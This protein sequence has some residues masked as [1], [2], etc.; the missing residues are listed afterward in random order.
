MSTKNQGKSST[1]ITDYPAHPFADAFERLSEPE[2]EEL[3]QDIAKNGQLNPVAIWKGVLLDGRNRMAACLQ[4]GKKPLVRELPESTNPIEF[5]L[6][7]NIYRRH[8]STGARAMFIIEAMKL[9]GKKLSEAKKSAKAEVSPRQLDD[10][11][12]VGKANP[13]LKTMVQAG[14]VP[15]NKAAT[16]AR[17][18]EEEQQRIVEGG[19]QAVKDAADRVKGKKPKPAKADVDLPEVF[20]DDNGDL[21]PNELWPVWRMKPQWLE[22]A[23]NIRKM[24]GYATEIRKFGKEVGSGILGEVADRIQAVAKSTLEDVIKDVP[25]VASVDGTWLSRKEAKQ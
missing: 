5:I 16:V 18:P 24:I 21:V 7:Q 10:A 11:S 14:E 15:L 3:K 20:Y 19:S 13:K 8:L 6:S 12:A 4:L 25:S 22:H 2:F 1:E 23:D 17:L 9:N